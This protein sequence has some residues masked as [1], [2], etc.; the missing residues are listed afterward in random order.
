MFTHHSLTSILLSLLSICSLTACT[1]TSQFDRELYLKSFIGKSSEYIYNNL[2]L[3]KIGYQV[4]QAPV[5]NQNQLAYSI[6]RT[7]MIP[8]PMTQPTISGTGV[9]PIPVTASSTQGYEATLQCRI[10]FQLNNNIAQ[11][12]SYTGQTC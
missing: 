9:I 2:D 10:V 6:E 8:I 5:L 12:V 11:S 7:L 3:S 4:N 1:T